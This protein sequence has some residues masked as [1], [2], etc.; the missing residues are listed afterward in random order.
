MKEKNPVVHFEMPYDNYQRLATFYESIFGWEMEKLGDE[1]GGYVLATTTDTN[2]D[3][4]PTTPGAINGGFFPKEPES[5]PMPSVVISVEDI[6]DAIKK[7]KIAGGKVTGEPV[8][9][10]GIGQYIAFIDSEGNR[11]GMMQPVPMEGVKQ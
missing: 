1:M 8:E 4:V 5:P 7:I 9:I 10:P 2:K 11:V 3:G 6:K